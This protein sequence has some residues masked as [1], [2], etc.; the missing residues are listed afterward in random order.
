MRKVLMASVAGLV[1]LSAVPAA[2]QTHARTESAA[3]PAAWQEGLFAVRADA[4]KGKVSI[5]LPAP[6]ADTRFSA[7]TPAAAKR[8]RLTAANSAFFV[9]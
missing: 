3:A 2:A 8:C 6:G 1:L 5:R 9:A 7:S 4:Q